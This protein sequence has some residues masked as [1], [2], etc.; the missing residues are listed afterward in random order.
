M[1]SLRYT[2]LSIALGTALNAAAAEAQATS[3]ALPVPPPAALPLLGQSA[4]DYASLLARFAAARGLGTVV[5]RDTLPA[6]L[7]AVRQATAQLLDQQGLSARVT[8]P[9][10]VAKVDPASLERMPVAVD[11]T[12]TSEPSARQGTIRG[13]VNPLNR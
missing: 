3:P 7:R 12:A 5:D 1:H 4:P 11:D 8:C 9:M 10:P 2:L 6:A 13:C